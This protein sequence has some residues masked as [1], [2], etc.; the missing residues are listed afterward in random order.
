MTFFI[1][2]L[3]QTGYKIRTSTLYHL[4]VGKRTSS[5]LLHGFFY[6]NLIYLGSLPNLKEATFQRE[7]QNLIAAEWITTNE[8]F[9]R[10]TQLGSEQL[11]EK[12]F[13]LVGLD[14]LR[15]GRMREDSWQLI[16]FAVQVLSYLSYG[17]KEYLPIEQRPFYLQQLKK[18]LAGSKPH[19]VE[20]FQH[21]LF[22]IFQQLPAGESDF[23]ANQFSGYGFQGKTA[24]QLLPMKYQEEPWNQLY[25]Q[26][27]IDLFLAQVKEGE[28]ARLISTLD[29]QNLN[30]SMLKTRE[31]F[32][33]GKSESEILRL[34]HLKQGTINDHFIEWALMEETFPFERFQLVDFSHLSI[35]QVIDQRYQEYDIPYLSFRLSQI[36]HLRKYTWN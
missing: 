19:L 8:G 7:I 15:Y 32:L 35:E 12:N 11:S 28:L 4:L 9:G 29:Q 36:Y 20:R 17:E 34:R 1:L 21:E 23:L 31:F 5:V 3:F 25:R 10:M 14:N 6:R 33:A 18:W 30:K 13:D 24:F 2:T 16:L 27:A 22:A 26:H